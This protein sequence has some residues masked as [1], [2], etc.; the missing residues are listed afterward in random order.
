MIYISCEAEQVGGRAV[1]ETLMF[2][3]TVT[4]VK[5]GEWRGWVL[6]PAS[7][8]KKC[9]QS[10][11]ELFRIVADQGGGVPLSRNEKGEEHTRMKKR[12]G[13]SDD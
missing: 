13:A 5:D 6:F 4:E 1:S 10:I 8:E 9:F 12:T 3:V 7:G 11:L 2:E